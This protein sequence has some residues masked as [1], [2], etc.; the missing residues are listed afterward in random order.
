MD[1]IYDQEYRGNILLSCMETCLQSNV[2][3]VAGLY[4]YIKI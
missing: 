4:T 3:N 1:Y 2:T